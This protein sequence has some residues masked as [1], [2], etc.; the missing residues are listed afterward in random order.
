MK[1][2]NAPSPLAGLK[3]LDLSQIMAGP[4]CT[5]VL[6]DLGA[7]VIKVEKAGKG[8]DSREMGP[9]VNEESASF[10]HINRNKKGIV[11]NLKDPQGREVLYDLARW[12]DV[13]VENFL[14]GVTKSLGVDYETLSRINPRLVYCSIS[15]FGQTGPY[16]HKGGFDLVAQ[17]MTGMMSMTGETGGRPLKAGIAIY[18]IGA[19]ITAVY[20]I[21]AA[22]IHQMNTGEG[23]HIDISLA[24]CGLPWFIWEAAAY[25]TTGI[26]PTATGSR[27]RVSAP[28][29]A[30]RTGSGY[31]VIGAA[32]QRSWERLC[33]GVLGRPDLIQDPR[34]ATNS[35]RLAH[36][37]ELEV[38]LEE[39]FAK[40]DAATWIARCEESG[41]P[42]GP[43]N[44]FGQALEDPHF[45]A[46]G[47]VQEVEHPVL[48]RMKMLGI[49][50]KFSRT[51]GSVDTAAPTLGQ[52]T[53]EVLRGLGMA[54]ERIMGLR[55][56]GVVQ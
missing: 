29:Q 16:A 10:A 4:Y 2:Q 56:T 31:I 23:Q 18:D 50:T 47:M 45:L 51:P 24:E 36:V 41:V 20:A 5:M 30:F 26:V 27:H 42:C 39:M 35:S 32:N 15:G 1:M 52:H 37:E 11:I 8:D 43:I 49:P 3:V 19:G 21:L 6:A 28:Y 46:R 44:D 38:L 54:P 22:R 13:V 40:A 34:F 55:S 17:G 53:D 14:V 48:G 7:E 33:N 9:Y 12:A 25:F